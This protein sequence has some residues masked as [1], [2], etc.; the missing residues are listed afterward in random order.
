MT[1][2]AA[3]KLTKKT[4]TTAKVPAR[5]ATRLGR[6]PS[7]TGAPKL[8]PEA[9]ARP[10]TKPREWALAAYV[11]I[12][13]LLNRPADATPLIGAWEDPEAGAARTLY[14]RAQGRDVRP[15]D[16]TIRCF[17]PPRGFV[18]WQKALAEME[19]IAVWLPMQPLLDGRA[20]KLGPCYVSPYAVKIAEDE[21]HPLFD[22]RGGWKPQAEFVASLKYFGGNFDALKLKG[23]R[24]GGKR[25][26]L[27]VEDGRQRV[28][29][30]RAADLEA[31][32][33]WYRG[34]MAEAHIRPASD[35]PSKSALQPP[36]LIET[37][38]AE[39]KGH[40]VREAQAMAAASNNQRRQ[41]QWLNLAERAAKLRAPT[42]GADGKEAPGLHQHEIAD[43]LGVSRQTVANL[44]L[45][46][47]LRPELWTPLRSGKLSQTCAYILAVLEHDKQSELWAKVEN[48]PAER[49]ADALRAL[50]AGRELAATAAAKPRPVKDIETMRQKLDA[51]E[52]NGPMVARA[53]LD[54][55]L[56][57]CGPEVF[58]N[59]PDDL[60]QQFRM[61]TVGAEPAK[62][63]APATK[64]RRGWGA[65]K[66]EE[67]EA[68]EAAGVLDSIDAHAFEIAGLTVEDAA[69]M[70]SIRDEPTRSFGEAYSLRR[71]TIE[72]IKGLLR[73][74]PLPSSEAV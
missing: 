72:G 4:K 68:W 50:I 71:I 10:P 22:S 15:G 46:Q 1:K 55:V 56:G 21:A 33:D 42:V 54:Y 29:G 2:Q 39:V 26:V 61:P 19:E 64:H 47:D 12:R 38:S 60:Q 18:S 45:L 51:L 49:R 23:L 13:G 27:Y 14:L 17:P 32:T 8:P 37:M 34:E 36:K 74:L 41:D 59:F 53:I 31:V 73:Q 24:E 3:K 65:Y 28:N 63:E 30:V 5:K 9:P 44:L 40:S 6:K 20:W 58:R 48:L 69:K 67:I 11:A 43:I 57:R 62:P 70:C 52:G 25:D 7:R 16:E 66:K 35:H